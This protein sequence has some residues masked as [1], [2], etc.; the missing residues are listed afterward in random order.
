MGSFGRH[1]EY[2]AEASPEAMVI[3]LL[4]PGDDPRRAEIHLHHYLFANL[5]DELARSVAAQPPIDDAHRA[6]LHDA[7][8]RLAAALERAGAKRC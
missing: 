2:G 6:A 8:S 3:K 7:A 1:S 5:L 4:R